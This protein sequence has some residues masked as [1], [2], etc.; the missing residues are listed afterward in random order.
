MFNAL[1]EEIFGDNK[2]M[3]TAYFADK[4]P[5]YDYMIDNKEIKVKLFNKI[6]NE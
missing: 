2:L 1:T 5:L 3:E 6:I 4:I